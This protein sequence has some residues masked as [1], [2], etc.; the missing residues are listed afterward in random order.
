[1]SDPDHQAPD[2]SGLDG[3]DAYQTAEDAVR[4]VAGWYSAQ[5]IAERRQP[6]PD[7]ERVQELRDRREAALAD[8]ARLTTVGPDEA[9][10]LAALYAARLKELTEP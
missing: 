4:E 7:D 2:F 8:A 1:M 10:R 6:V 5:I 9:S 3:G